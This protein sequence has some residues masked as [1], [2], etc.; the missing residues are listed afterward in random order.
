MQ[1]KLMKFDDIITLKVIKQI[2]L[3]FNTVILKLIEN[4]IFSKIVN[5]ISSYSINKNCSYVINLTL[6]QRIQHIWNF[7]EFS[8]KTEMLAHFSS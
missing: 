7:E 1:L 3:K 6:I 4:F 2:K 8:I 5:C